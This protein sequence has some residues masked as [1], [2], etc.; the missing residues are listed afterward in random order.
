[1]LSSDGLQTLYDSTLTPFNNK[2]GVINVNTGDSGSGKTSAV[3]ETE[4][5]RNCVS[6]L[7]G[8]RDTSKSN[9]SSGRK[10]KSVQGHKHGSLNS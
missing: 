2:R 8:D 1:M 5:N 4:F 10:S 6:Y 9:F 7:A 3:P